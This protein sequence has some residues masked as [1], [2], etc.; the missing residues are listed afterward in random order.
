MRLENEFG[1]GHSGDITLRLLNEGSFESK[2]RM[3]F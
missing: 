2:V 3:K 1:T